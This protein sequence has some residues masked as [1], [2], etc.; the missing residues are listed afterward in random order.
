MVLNLCRDEHF[1]Q[2]P[3]FGLKEKLSETTG[4]LDLTYYQIKELRAQL[5]KAALMT[6]EFGNNYGTKEDVKKYR[7]RLV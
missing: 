1:D 4:Q 3:S 5:P 2:I 6:T 7:E